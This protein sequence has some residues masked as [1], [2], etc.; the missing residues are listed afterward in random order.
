[1]IKER[2]GV[3][4]K[5]QLKVIGRGTEEVISEEELNKK[6]KKS[7]ESDKP[8]NIKAGFDP[9]APDIHLGHTILLNKMKQFQELGHQVIFLIGDFT[10]MIGDPSG[11][12][13]T[14]PVLTKEEV[15]KNSETYKNQIFKILD[16]KKTKIVFNSSW[17]EKMNAED[18]IKLCATYTVARMLERDDFLKR[19]KEQRPIFIHEFLYPLVQGYDSVM[20]KAD[21]E[22][23]GTDQKFN[24]LV[25]REIQRTYGIE[26]QVII[27]LPILEGIDGKQ[28]MSKSLGNYIGVDEPPK[29]IFGKIMSINDEIMIRYFE[30]LSDISLKEVGRIKID[31]EQGKMN[32]KD[33]KVCLAREIVER[34]Y[35][36]EAARDASLEFDQVFKLKGFPEDAE[37]VQW[38]YG[39]EKKWLPQILKELK[40]TESSSEAKRLI[41]QGAVAINDEKITD[42]DTYLENGAEY[43]IKVGKKKFLKIIPAK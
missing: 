37:E 39:E 31:I 15:I 14:R 1:M 35:D 18:L 5:E 8:L 17:M 43:R 13:E 7:I 10:G 36:Q 22:L 25:A 9:T 38:P 32:P 29:E 20:L 41:K 42:I 40:V 33:A 16:K 23:G 2:A 3:N 11:K 24:L 34:F 6:L 4:L 19:Y 21:I 12:N 26:P 27:T 28:K 30:L